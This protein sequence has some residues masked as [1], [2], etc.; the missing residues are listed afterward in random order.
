VFVCGDF[1]D[2]PFSSP[3]NS[4]DEDFVDLYTL[5]NTDDTLTKPKDSRQNFSVIFGYDKEAERKE[6]G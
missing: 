5:T 2:K 6:S 4:M 1:N 3:I